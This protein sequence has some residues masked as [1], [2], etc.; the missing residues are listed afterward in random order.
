MLLDAVLCYGY[1]IPKCIMQ[2]VSSIG[3][4]RCMAAIFVRL[5]LCMQNA[6]VMQKVTQQI[7]RRKNKGV[8]DKGLGI[9]K[10]VI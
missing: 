1:L 7:K 4:G 5:Q 10:H 2:R 3:G 6:R 8:E 9:N